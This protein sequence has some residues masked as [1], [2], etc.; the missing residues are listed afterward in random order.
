MSHTLTRDEIDALDQV[1]KLAKSAKPGAC[2]ARNAKHL[3]G[4]KY[5]AVRK[6]GGYALTGK[7]AE[8][9][10]LSQCVGGLR[11][12]ASDPAFKLDAAV[13][14]FLGRKGHIVAGAVAGEFTVT[15]KGHECL[16]DIALNT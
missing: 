5:L 12:L 10:L 7:G 8:A 14:A 15:P 11:S 9:L 13:A 1:G 6:D 16:A 2:I 3:V 4:I